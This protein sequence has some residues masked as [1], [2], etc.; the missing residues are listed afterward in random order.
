MVLQRLNK[1]MKKKAVTLIE[2][3]VV[4]A[5]IVITAWLVAWFLFKVGD[6]Y[7]K[8]KTPSSQTSQPRSLPIAS[9]QKGQSVSIVG[10]TNVVTITEVNLNSQGRWEYRVIVNTPNGPEEKT[11]SESALRNKNETTPIQ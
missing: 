7:T 10:T 11:F 5:I 3:M 4:I 1:Y 9:Y 2:L 6:Q 8:G